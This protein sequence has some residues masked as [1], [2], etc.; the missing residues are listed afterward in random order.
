[1][2]VVLFLNS[3]CNARCRH[4]YISYNGE[5]NPEDAIAVVQK[6]QSRG[7]EVVIA[8]SETLLNPDY[9][10][11]YKQAE[12]R[13][14]LT[15]GIILDRDRSLFFALRGHG[16]EE[17][18]LSMHFGIQRDIWSVSD[19][20]VA[21]VI[22]SACARNFRVSVFTVI[23]SRNYHLLGQI[24]ETAVLLGVKELHPLRFV[25]AGKGASMRHM[26]LSA[27]EL[28]A[29]FGEVDRIRKKYPKSVLEINL[30]GNFGPR[31]GT[32]GVALAKE[33]KYCPAGIDTVAIDPQNNVYG[34]PFLMQ[35]ENKIGRY[36][37]GKIIIEKNLFEGRR[38]TCIAHLI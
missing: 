34:C 23:S 13:H 15:N 6:L 7:Y 28:S 17:L 1:M 22:G 33:N 26:A 36:E 2:R 20:L 31:P 14:L 24:C 8:G 35:P 29:F 4:C 12:Q 16:I 18:V 25:C 3:K 32:G 38:D 10:E 9:L 5:R 11:V 19:N 21:R 27:E 30:H 37:N